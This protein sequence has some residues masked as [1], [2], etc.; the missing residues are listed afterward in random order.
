M[1]EVNKFI[2]R[3]VKKLFGLTRTKIRLAHESNTVYVKPRPLPLVELL[4]NTRIETVDDAEDRLGELISA[5]DY[6]NPR[7]VSSTTLELMDIIE[8][9]KYM[10]E[11][12][13]LCV[14]L[15]DDDFKKIEKHA[16]DGEKINLLIM[17]EKRLAGINIYV[18]YEP[19]KG[20][21][22]LGRVPTTLSYSL[23]YAFNSNILS[24]DMELKNTRIMLGHQTLIL[25]SISHAIQNYGAKAL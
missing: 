9:V 6:S 2:V 24:S 16:S 12:P 15:E 18:G 4:S 3:G 23:A 20:V 25:N 1:T 22:H 5:I 13:E 7:S 10:F 8:G 21:L 14:L 19:P 11:P 17:S